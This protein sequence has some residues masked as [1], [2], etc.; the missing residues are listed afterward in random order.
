MEEEQAPTPPPPPEQGQDWGARFST[1]IFDYNPYY[2]G[3]D[4]APSE[5]TISDSIYLNS[6]MHW[7]LDIS[8]LGGSSHSGDGSQGQ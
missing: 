5:I 7:I 1:E 8:Q 2:Y 6:P 3:K 4:G